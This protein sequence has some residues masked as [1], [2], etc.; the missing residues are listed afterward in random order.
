LLSPTS[1]SARP[2]EVWIDEVI[3]PAIRGVQNRDFPLLYPPFQPLLE[4]LGDTAQRVAADWV[5][6]PVRTEEADDAP[7]CWNG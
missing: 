1:I 6:L 7:G 2:F 3:A 4:L 5:Q